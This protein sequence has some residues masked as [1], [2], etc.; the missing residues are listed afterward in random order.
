MNGP[1][2]RFAIATSDRYAGVFR[3]FIEAGWEPVKLFVCDVD[4]WMHFNKD[5][6]AMAEGFKID[7]QLSRL[8]ERDLQDLADRQCD[9]LVVAGYSWRIPE[10]EGR[11]KYAVNFH[12]SPL[13]EGRGPYPQ[14][15]AL[16]EN[17]SSW[18]VTCHKLDRD[19]DTGDI[20]DREEFPLTPDERHETLDFKIQMAVWLLATRVAADLPILWEQARPQGEGTYWPH[21]SDEPERVLDF[22]DTVESN[23]RRIRAFGNL[24]CIAVVNGINIFVGS[25]GGRQ[26]THTYEPGS[27][28]VKHGRSMLFAVK[29]GFIAITGWSVIPQGEQ[30]GT[31]PR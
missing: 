19:F 24:E 16:L 13:P 1:P 14:V 31:A 27:L 10:W 11:L 21:W 5:V 9:L 29:D 30:S 22:S 3:A 25:A 20:L 6:V 15:R 8:R 28:V 2:M 17:R 12:P 7:I 23:M 4:N 26:E 18:A